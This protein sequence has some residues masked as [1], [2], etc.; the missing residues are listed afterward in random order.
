MFVVM[1]GH[2]SFAIQSLTKQLQVLI[3]C[4]MDNSSFTPRDL[5]LYLT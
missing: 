3:K 2:F 5:V 1:L 4:N